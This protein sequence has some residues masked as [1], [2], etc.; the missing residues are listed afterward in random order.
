M[1]NWYSLYKVTFR[2]KDLALGGKAS[3]LQRLFEQAFI[4]K[5]APK[6]P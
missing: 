2:R 1:K 6:A 4:I 3:S 5:H